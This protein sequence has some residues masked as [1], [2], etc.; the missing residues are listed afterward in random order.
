MSELTFEKAV[1]EL[2]KI[3]LALESGELGLEES[4][5]YY[6]KGTKLASFCSEKLKE[7]ELKIEQLSDIKNNNG[8]Q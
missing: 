2:E 8:E 4:M 7:A 3:T 6:E 1:N 5:K